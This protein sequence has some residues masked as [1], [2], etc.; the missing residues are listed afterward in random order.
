MRQRKASKTLRACLCCLAIAATD[1]V[2]A[3]QEP[4]KR[5]GLWVTQKISESA[6]NLAGFEAAIRGN[7]HLAG[8]C[9]TVGWKEI[10]TEPGKPD[11]SSIDKTVTVLHRIGM[12]YELALKPGVDTPAYVFRQGAQSLQTS[13]TNP[14]RANFGETVTIPVPW[15]PIYQRNFSRVIAQLGERYAADPLCVG[16]VLTCANFMS[17]EMHLPKTPADRAKWQEMGDYGTKLLDVYK[18]YTDEWAKAFPKQQISL[19][20]S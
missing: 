9:L 2:F 14:H 7:P 1:Q 15:D 10:E 17:K 20:L 16:V 19:H 18:K 4:P 11:F 5:T 6:A 8:V 12:K 13:I 3:E